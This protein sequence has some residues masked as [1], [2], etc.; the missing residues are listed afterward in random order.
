MAKAITTT[1]SASAT[2]SAAVYL[3]GRRLL[4]IEFPAD[5]T[6]TSI[7]FKNGENGTVV[8]NFAND[9][10]Y[11]IAKTVSK[12]V[13]VDTRVTDCLTKLVIVSQASEAAER[14][15]VLYLSEI[16]Q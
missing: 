4:A 14:T 13:P 16:S 5:L 2:N 1:I 9:G 7:S 8:R 11:S 6:G 12:I 15:L 10:D 3:G